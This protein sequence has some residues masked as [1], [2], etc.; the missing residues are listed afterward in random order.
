[1]IDLEKNNF[2]SGSIRQNVLGEVYGYYNGKRFNFETIKS[3]SRLTYSC[4]KYYLY[5]SEKIIINDKA[6]DEAKKEVKEE[7]K[8][9]KENISCDPGIRTLLSGITEDTIVEIGNNLQTIMNKYLNRIDEIKNNKEIPNRIKRKVEKICNNKMRNIIDEVHWKTINYLV[10]N[11][12]TIFIGNMSTKSI[13]S[14]LNVVQ[15]SPIIKKMAQL[16]RLNE[17]KQRLKYKC[18]V[19][20]VNFKETNEK[21]TTKMCSHCGNIKENV[22]SAKVYNCDN[23]GLCIGRDFQ[24][25][26]TQYIGSIKQ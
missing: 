14:N 22:G 8:E 12:K 10:S 18:A 4:G 15:L 11:Y 20:N 25:A 2:S 19:H 16:I 23:C 6:K 1:M 17:F 24:S 9:K 21:Y 5:V 3:D 26:R 7:V 13:I